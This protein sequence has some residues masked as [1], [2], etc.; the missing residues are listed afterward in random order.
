MKKLP[1]KCSTLTAKIVRLNPWGHGKEIAAAVQENWED[2]KT[3]WP[4]ENRQWQVDFAAKY[5]LDTGWFFKQS[6]LVHLR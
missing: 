1:A 5:R 3:N 4:A 2:L 6:I